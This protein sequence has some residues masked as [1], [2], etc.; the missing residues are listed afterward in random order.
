VAV[1]PGDI[2]LV[3]KVVEGVER[4]IRLHLEGEGRLLLVLTKYDDGP[5][6]LLR[7]RYFFT[8]NEMLCCLWS[9]KQ[10]HVYAFAQEAFDDPVIRMFLEVM[11]MA[12]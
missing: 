9:E 8:A 3:R 12:E 6:W 7:T 2:L 4:G 10:Y 5:A 1:I 11:D